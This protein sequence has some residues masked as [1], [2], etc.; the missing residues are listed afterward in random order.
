MKV[1]VDSA[2]LPE[3]QLSLKERRSIENDFGVF[4]TKPQNPKRAINEQ[5]GVYD[6]D[7]FFAGDVI[8]D[9]DYFTK[10]ELIEKIK[11]LFE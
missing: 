11:K 8:A 4:L 5:T 2:T 9:G 3:E 7:E 1:K 10:E 6:E